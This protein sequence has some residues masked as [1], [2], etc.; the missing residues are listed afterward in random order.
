MADSPQET[1]NEQNL[2]C[3]WCPPGCKSCEPDDCECYAHQ[4]WPDTALDEQ[5]AARLARC[6]DAPDCDGRTHALA[7]NNALYGGSRG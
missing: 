7:C 3:R 6:L 2:R 1:E 4:D 5:A